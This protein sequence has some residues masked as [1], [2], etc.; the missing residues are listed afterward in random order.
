[1]TYKTLPEYPG[2]KI[3]SNGEI[4]NSS[5]KFLSKHYRKRNPYDM[6]SKCDITVNLQVDGCNKYPV[7]VHRL[8]ARAFLPNPNNKEQV[9]HIDGNPENND[10]SNL[11]WATPQENIQHSVDNKLNAG[12][13]K[14]CAIYKLKCTEILIRTFVN[15]NEAASHIG[16]SN[17]R[18]AA[19]N[20]SKAASINMSKLDKD[21]FSSSGYV[22]RYS[23]KSTVKVSKVIQPCSDISTV[24]YKQIAGTRYLITAEG[25]VWDT[26]KNKY[27]T[28]SVSKDSKTGDE[29]LT[30]ALHVEGRTYKTVRVA[31]VVCDCFGIKRSPGI[32]YVDNN[33]GNCAANNL[34]HRAYR[35]KSLLC[36]YKQVFE[37]EL[38]STFDTI[39]AAASFIDMAMAT[40]AEVANKN[41]DVAVGDKPY[42][43][44]GY[45]VRII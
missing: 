34:Q 23:T 27:I 37:E 28:C 22:W 15:C 4:Q 33:P 25:C 18:S 39:A 43:C 26:D 13:Y 29:Y 9:N 44:N 5:G 8:V 21:A 42:T 3:Y 41:R 16:K 7:T 36:M 6:N 10:V 30:C 20:I 17:I 24:P 12:S 40:T 14:A 1:M 45:V 19:S 32:H 11:E 31:S 2:Y 38:I 35:A